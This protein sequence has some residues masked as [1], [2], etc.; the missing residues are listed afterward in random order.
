MSCPIP[1]NDTGKKTHAGH[2]RE[3]TDG[4]V[5]A[6]EDPNAWQEI[7]EHVSQNSEFQVADIVEAYIE[8]KQGAWPAKL[9]LTLTGVR[10]LIGRCLSSFE[11]PKASLIEEESHEK[12]TVKKSIFCYL[13][14]LISYDV[15]SPVLF[16]RL[17]LDLVYY[18]I[19]KADRRK[20]GLSYPISLFTSY[21]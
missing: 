21:L 12:K 9:Y 8:K 3:T 7:F 17:H 5:L 1:K 15:R 2:V 11:K 19:G 10:M 20:D 13:A 4:F 6:E 16:F 18:R 14:S